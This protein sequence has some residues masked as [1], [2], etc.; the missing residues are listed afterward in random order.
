VTAV[1][2]SLGGSELPEIFSDTR[3]NMS[4]RRLSGVRKGENDSD[5]ARLADLQSCLKLTAV[6][7]CR[8][9][10]LANLG[11]DPAVNSAA[12]NLDRLMEIVGM[13]LSDSGVR[14][15]VV[16]LGMPRDDRDA[17]NKKYVDDR[18]LGG[19]QLVVF[20]AR[21]GTVASRFNLLSFSG[22]QR[23]SYV[24][25]EKTKLVKISVFSTATDPISVTVNFD[26]AEFA[27]LGWP[28]KE[29]TFY[30]KPAKVTF[31]HTLTAWLFPIPN[32]VQSGDHY[33]NFFFR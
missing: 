18:T 28:G 24:H 23:H 19:S 3:W 17:V 11:S 4:N 33:V 22:P 20:H 5:L 15:R 12:V 27:K 7:S 29:A 8:N 14:R 2:G 16:D 6:G 26:S 10:R 1:G 9:A 13:Q 32:T 31:M 25:L 30:P 21:S